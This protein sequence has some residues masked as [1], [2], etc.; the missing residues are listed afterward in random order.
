MLDEK[1][2]KAIQILR[3]LINNTQQELQDQYKNAVSKNENDIGAKFASLG[4]ISVLSKINFALLD[5][6]FSVDDTLN[7]FKAFNEKEKIKKGAPKPKV[8]KLSYYDLS[9]ES[10]YHYYLLTDSALKLYEENNGFSYE[11]FIKIAKKP[12]TFV[13]GLRKISADTPTIEDI[14][15]ISEEDARWAL[16]YCDDKFYNLALTKGLIKDEFSDLT[17]VGYS[18][19]G[20]AVYQRPNSHKAF[21]QDGQTRAYGRIYGIG[22]DN[23]PKQYPEPKGYEDL[24][25]ET[26]KGK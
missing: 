3:K 26:E 13:K 7:W 1:D 17:W 18:Q 23:E 19:D 24:P 6:G 22:K 5:N 16:K 2:I 10:L 20:Q 15:E 14:G 21:Y 11:E 4:F 12:T 8:Y 25:Y 9:L